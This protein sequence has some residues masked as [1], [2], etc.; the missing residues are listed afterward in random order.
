MYGEVIYHEMSVP[1]QISCMYICK[2]RDSKALITYHQG[3]CQCIRKSVHQEKNKKVSATVSGLFSTKISTYDGITYPVTLHSG[4]W[5]KKEKAIF[6]I[7]LFSRISLCLQVHAFHVIKIS[8]NFQLIRGY[9]Y[10]N[11][12]YSMLAY[13]Y[14]MR[15]LCF[16][17]LLFYFDLFHFQF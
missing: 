6:F 3:F 15:D 4:A 5:N 17:T 7:F 9:L 11:N 16:S 1:S 12:V 2:F 10:L 14:G 8:Q 13:L